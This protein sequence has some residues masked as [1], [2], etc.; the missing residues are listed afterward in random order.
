M[1]EELGM[2]SKRGEK[3]E[4]LGVNGERFLTVGEERLG[5]GR[6]RRV[7]EEGERWEKS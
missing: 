4:G 2:S 3:R 6:K 5:L 7:G 1:K